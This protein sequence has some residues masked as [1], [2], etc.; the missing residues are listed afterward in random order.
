MTKLIWVIKLIDFS[1]L[2]DIREDHDLTQE[3]MAE[4]LG[5]KRSTYSLWE[6]GINII[7]IDDLSN[8][9]DYFDLNIDY[10]VGL[11]KNRSNNGNKS[12][13]DIN[14]LGQ[15]LKKLRK[16]NKLTQEEF[17]KLINVSQAAI[18]KYESGKIQ[19][20]FSNLYILSKKFNISIRELLSK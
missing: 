11:S 4:I 9:A 7:P 5:V 1:I 17:G 13:F 15:N 12:N 19:I 20:S 18:N 6:L 14:I 16:K 3:K 2:K 8:F 10:I